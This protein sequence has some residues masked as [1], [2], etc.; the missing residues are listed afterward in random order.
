MRLCLHPSMASHLLDGE[1]QRPL[2]NPSR[3]TLN[4]SK[5]ELDMASMV[6]CRRFLLTCNSD[7][8][9][10]LRADASPQGGRDYFVVETD[11]FSLSPEQ[12]FNPAANHPISKALA[13]GRVQVRT[14]LLPLQILGCR[15]SSSVH[16]AK[17]LITSLRLESADL[18][19]SL[20]RTATLMFD[21]GAEA[22]IWSMPSQGLPD[23][24]LFNRSLPI[25]DADH[26][27]HHAP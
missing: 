15:A 10:H 6:F 27:L 19:V 13:E 7:W 5:I 23:Q 12:P 25:A 24:R 16:K 9:L 21:F 2:P 3:A 1:Q 20:S 26:G 4:R 17:A 22:G 11:V 8:W 14:R 18:E